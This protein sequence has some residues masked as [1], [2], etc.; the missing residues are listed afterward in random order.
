LIFGTIPDGIME[1]AK[2]LLA[3]LEL[4]EFRWTINDILEQPE[5]EMNVVFYLKNLGEKIRIQ[6]RNQKKSSGVNSADS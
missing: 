2:K 4:T 6:S 1:H 3:I 5:Q